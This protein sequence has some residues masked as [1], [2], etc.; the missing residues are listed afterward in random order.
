MSKRPPRPQSPRE[1]ARL[2]AA[3]AL[4]K[5][6]E[7]L[8]LMQ[9]EELS[10]YTDYFLLANGRST[11]QVTAIAE[12]VAQVMKKAGVRPLGLDGLRQG[13]WAL[14]DFGDV[15]V[16]IFHAPVRELYDLD[17]LWGDAPREDM[18]PTELEGLIPDNQPT[19]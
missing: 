17:S 15:V 16:H 19:P 11:R 8:L 1:A 7:N 10:G 2:C 14:L 5:K 9:V 4:A 12:H 3:A 18:D 13:R 6:A